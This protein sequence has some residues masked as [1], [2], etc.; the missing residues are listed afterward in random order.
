MTYD[1]PTNNSLTDP[2]ARPLAWSLPRRVCGRSKGGE[3]K[4]G[5]DERRVGVE[6]VEVRLGA[7]VGRSGPESGSKERGSGKYRSRNQV[8]WRRQRLE[9]ELR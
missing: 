8:G 7:S 3:T 5:G 9:L 4:R 6:G 1:S 2:F